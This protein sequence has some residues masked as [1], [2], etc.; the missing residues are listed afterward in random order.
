[1]AASKGRA[2][3]LASLFFLTKN[4]LDQGIL[5]KCIQG[6]LSKYT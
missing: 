6:T 4:Y 1:M 2:L 3:V 5:S